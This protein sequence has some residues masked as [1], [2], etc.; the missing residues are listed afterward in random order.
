MSSG[1]GIN[2]SQ[3]GTVVVNA[4]ETVFTG[5]TGSNNRYALNKWS[6]DGF[7]T[8]NGDLTFRDISNSGAAIRGNEGAI[9]TIQATGDIALSDVSTKEQVAALQS[10]NL[11]GKNI[12]AEMVEQYGTDMLGAVFWVHKGT[13]A[14]TG[15]DGSGGQISVED[16]K[17]LL[18]G[19][20]SAAVWVDNAGQTK[21]NK[22]L[23][24]DLTFTQNRDRDIV[25]SGIHAENGSHVNVGAL[26]KISDLKNS[27]DY[28][29]NIAG[30]HLE[31]KEGVGGITPPGGGNEE[32][33]EATI[34]GASQIRISN[35]TANGA[36][37]N[38]FGIYAIG[39]DDSSAD[40]LKLSADSLVVN[41]VKGDFSYGLAQLNDV[42]TS[43]ASADFSGISAVKEAAGVYLR[44]LEA[45]TAS[46]GCLSVHDLST[47]EGG[48]V[49]L[50]DVGNG[51]VTANSAQLLTKNELKYQ[52][53]F[54]GDATSDELGVVETAI[55][56]V[57]GGTVELNNAE[58]A[59]TIVGSLVA[60]YGSALPEDDVVNGG[61]IVIGGL[62]TR[63]YGDVFA[64]NGGSID[65]ALKQGSL[66]D[67]QIDDYHELDM[68]LASDSVFRNSQFR[69]D[70]GN[71]LDVTKG[72]SVKLA[73]NGATWIARGQ[74]FVKD[75]AFGTQGGLIDLSQ[76][77][78][79]SV[80]VANLS[81][82][83]EFTMK[84]GAYTEEGT[85][86]T[87]MLYIQNVEEGAHYTINAVLDGVTDISQLENIRFATVKNGASSDL[88]TVQIKDQGFHDVNIPVAQEDYQVGDAD[89][90]RFNGTDG[91]GDYKPGTGYV[92]AIFG[93]E[94]QDGVSTLED[95]DS[96]KNYFIDSA[97]AQTSV[98]DP[99]QAIIATARALYY[100]AIEIDRF[101]QRY[102][103]R[104]YDENNKS[105][106]ARVRQDRWGTAA[107]V[108]DFKSQNTT[109]QIGFDYTRP[110]DSGKMIFGAAVDLMDGNTDYESIDGSG[111]TKRYAVSAYATYLGDNGGYVDVVGKVGRLSN[112]YA[113]KLDSGAG[114]SADYMNWMAGISV[115]VGHQLSLDNS[116]WFFE[117][118]IQAQYVFVSDNDYSNGQTEIEQDSIHSFITR[119]GFRAGRWFG[120]EK[121]TNVYFKTDVMHEWAG[122]Q[123]IHVSDKTTAAGGESFNMDN[124]GTWFDVGLGFQAPVGKSFYAYGDAEYRFGNDLDQ[125]WVFNFGGKYV[126]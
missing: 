8:F 66:I 76:S 37:K 2:W 15:E 1:S 60:G 124:K 36:G 86:Q 83:G 55:R 19:Y 45:S 39:A 31:G 5:T 116:R 11:I 38:A 106:W 88:F 126:F 62:N 109:Y 105:L 46:F 58:G 118:Q 24:S 33:D 114:V 51:T 70:Q 22:I 65:I 9:G 84:L 57:A 67:G 110:S 16:S 73:L 89:N 27:T 6:G 120:E 47:T 79:S 35:I 17:L 40:G 94:S 117:P 4:K 92:D 113:V 54:E 77:T 103:D 87:D 12:T 59:Y 63:I 3:N 10:T 119:A 61:K 112:E 101:N 68:G 50:V 102:G 123:G 32:D 7:I 98:S 96:S 52:G 64:G 42:T 28:G 78:N 95:G 104:R 48:F 69:D 44:G 85:I 107:G 34:L 108:G 80:S 56:A 43:F 26:I 93:D 75:V 53:H 13:L 29:G 74:N 111:E 122:D 90:E 100:N 99:G 23:I 18:H 25:G 41:S 21:A 82:N 81:G 125:T 97:G 20:G 30:I 115:E 121:N 91:K 49:S 72:G 14:A 71:V